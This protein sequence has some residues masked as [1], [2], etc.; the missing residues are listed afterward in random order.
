MTHL[1]S[2]LRKLPGS[3]W[4][5]PTMETDVDT[6]TVDDVVSGEE[7]CRDVLAPEKPTAPSPLRKKGAPRAGAHMPSISFDAEDEALALQKN[8]LKNK[9][10]H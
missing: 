6:E 2:L 10:V 1:T 8:R 4:T 7:F 5:A 9:P 3:R